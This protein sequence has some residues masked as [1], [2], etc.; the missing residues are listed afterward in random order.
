MADVAPK[1]VIPALLE[2]FQDIEP[3]KWD[4]HLHTNEDIHHHTNEDIHHHEEKEQNASR[5][6]ERRIKLGEALL[7]IA[8]RCGD[9]L[10]KYGHGF[11]YAFLNSIRA[12]TMIEMETSHAAQQARATMMPP[13][14]VRATFCASC[15]SNLAEVYIY[16]YIIRRSIRRLDL[17]HVIIVMIIT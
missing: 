2:A 4:T 11:V 5:A 6:M 15:L 9:T 17:Y 12:M 10:P 7:F 14:V 8:R 1:V 3:T 13:R 16:I